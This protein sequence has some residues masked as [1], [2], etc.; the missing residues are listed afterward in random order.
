MKNPL[1]YSIAVA[2]QYIVT[3]DLFVPASCLLSVAYGICSTLISLTKDIICDVN[4]LNTS[5]R[6]KD[7]RFKI[8]KQ[9]SQLIE[10]HSDARQLSA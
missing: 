8:A 2:F 3:V 7:D 10:I 9:F 1:G 5:G 6:A 4:S